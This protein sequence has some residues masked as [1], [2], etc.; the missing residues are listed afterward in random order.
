MYLIEKKNRI[1][2][3]FLTIA[4]TFLAIIL[5]NIPV[6]AEESEA[7]EI[8][9][10][11]TLSN[12]GRVSSMTDG[13]YNTRTSFSSGD[14]IVIT[15]SEAMYSLY[16]KWDLVPSQWTLTY[17]DKT[18][19]CGTDGFLH[20][21]IKIPEGTTSMTITF[22]SKEAIC[23]LH[24]Y[25]SGTAPAQVQTW[26]KPCDKADILVFATHADDEIL[27]LG[28]VLATYG[29][30]QDLA[31]QVAY[32]CEFTSTAKIREHEKLDGLWVSG[33]KNYPVC[34]D[35]PDLYSTT[36]EAAKK[37]YNY[38]DLKSFITGTIRRFKP[39]VVVTQDFN[40]EY[41]HG[42]HMI[43]S[44]AVA[45]SVDTSKDASVYPETA[46]QYG[47]WDVPKTYIHLY[48]QNKITINLRVPLANMGNRTAIEIA[49]EAY[50]QHVSQQWCWFYVSDDYEYS[51]ADFGLYRTLVGNDTGNDMLENIT[52]YEEQERLA[53]E[54]AEKESIE[55]S[56]A[57]SVAEEQSIAEEQSRSAKEQSAKSHKSSVIV[58]I[59]IIFVLLLAA[60]LIYKYY[61][62]VQSRKR[63]SS[64]R[65]R[66]R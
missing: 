52:T 51:C 63:H 2:R 8:T 55:S 54:A 66:K 3:L 28:G 48:D 20:E 6:R 49:S 57:A 16:I 25:S 32:M 17:N 19:N 56:I 4:A 10:D 35:F 40:G 5:F 13:S 22:A 65:R 36:L 26:K 43:L 47:T 64:H 58:A 45:D 18:V 21:Y 15:S 31:V 14:T 23:D 59:A 61:T 33:I 9:P 39:L 34:G 44:K 12:G 37:Q 24:T 30:G 53:R 1:L 46:S 7:T 38:E 42:G 50:K 41:G 29:G 62:L 11:I 27:F 60:F